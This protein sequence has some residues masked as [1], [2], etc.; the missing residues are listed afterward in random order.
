VKFLYDP[1]YT[2]ATKKS[3]SE[4][5]AEI[6][7][8]SKPLPTAEIKT[9]KYDHFEKPSKILGETEI[10]EYDETFENEE[11]PEP[12]AGVLCS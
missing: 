7:S 4:R 6:Q 2:A 9:P 10:H 12:N 5:Q 1:A 11:I 3:L 8:S